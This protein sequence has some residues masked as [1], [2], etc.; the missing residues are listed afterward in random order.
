MKKHHLLIVGI[1]S[2]LG[3]N[4]CSVKDQQLDNPVS[5]H[6][7]AIPEGIKKV[8]SVAKNVDELVIPFNQYE[9]DN[10]LTVIIHPDKS[11]P[12]VHVDVTYHVGSAREELGKS[13]FAHFFEHMMF[14]GSEN[15][16][17][18]Q[19]FSLITESGGTLN[20]STNT[21]RT[22]YYETV[23][24]NQLE[25][26][27][28]LESD[29]MG[30]FLDAVTTEKFENQR[31][32]VKN[33]RGQNYD[34]RPYGLLRERVNE[35]MYPEGHPYSW[36]TIGYIEDL[37]RANLNDLKEFFLRWYGPNNA[38]LTIGGDLD[39][40]QTLAWVKQYFGGIPRGPEV[41]EPEYTKITLPED[42]YISMED[43]VS[44]PLMYMT[45]PTV[46]LNHPDEAPLD[47]L[48]SILGSG[49]TS[50]LYKNMVKNGKAVQAQAGHGCQELGCQFSL[51]GLPTPG[52]SLAELEQI[53]RAS[54]QEFEERGGAED[55]DLE[56][57]KASIVSGMVYGLESVSGK[58]SQLA[59]YQTYRNNPNGI[60]DDVARYENVTKDDVMRVYK[61]YIKNQHAVIM[62]IVP[63]GQLDG[64]IKP[65]TWQ[66]YQRNI[67][68]TSKD[69]TLAL[70]PGT[71]SFDRSVI[72][73]SGKNPSI[74]V[75]AIYRL[76]TNNGIH[77]L[78]TVNDEVPTTTLSLR[79]A[80]GQTRESIDKLGLASLTAAMMGEATL[81]SSAEELSNE[82]QKLGS[83][84]SFSSGD[85]F[86]TVNI[87]TLTKNLTETLEI[88]VE[89]LT[90]PKFAE[91]DFL[92]LQ[93]QQVEGLKNAKK[94][95]SVTAT[96]SFNKL[97]FGENNSFSYG[98][99]GLISTVEKL[100][101][102]D[103]KNFYAN[104]Y[105]PEASELIVVS[106]LDEKHIESAI[107]ILGS[108]QG[109]SSD[110][111][112]INPYPTLEAGT[113]YFID[114]P[115]AAQ[116]EIR[117]GKRA[118]KYDSTGEYYRADLMNYNLGG[119]FNSRIN[120]N[121]REDKGYTYGARSFFSGNDIR[122]YY[123]AQAGVRAD[124]TA[125]SIVQFRKEIAEFAKQGMT[126]QELQFVKSAIGQ[127]DARS[128]ETP[129][130]KLGF[131]STI[132]TYDLDTSF[133]DEQNA[134]LASITKEEL[135]ALATKH[136]KLDEMITVVVGDKEAVFEDLKPLFEN[137]VELDAHGKPL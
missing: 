15:V 31:E 45:F 33:E 98:N 90:K 40:A 91:V 68:E 3:L 81:T 27:L 21:D 126:D 71:S 16:A 29:R 7:I 46:H 87:R 80:A 14:Q 43:N 113:L 39:E 63:K 10:G 51:L 84:V 58:V 8:T 56:R 42:R 119:A 72:P 74:H 57:V 78:G 122:G 64:I 127:R 18:E 117:I 9:L 116:S 103:V 124:T 67:P 107:A 105:G 76:D 11:D 132:M 48:M 101:L 54:L 38:T 89:K 44:L 137:I 106:D 49:K 99:G 12:L 83:Q 23:P 135:N 77:V 28:W 62:S 5:S 109:N 114:K 26:M 69:S 125:D 86:T 108:W 34:N 88:A 2:I 115:G 37:N 41:L 20:G 134:I 61:K 96:D 121:L 94:N 25:R 82:L 70:R 130:Q 65:D 97:V 30:F 59:A 79:I 102:D 1:A 133:K 104:H 92:R 4:A 111:P 17:D 131:L 66:R 47:V 52:T 32:T 93:K 24:A 53:A 120:L 95:A 128:F 75:P 50:L 55:D 85:Q 100:T 118:L 6:E 112:K 136:L 60:G 35:A 110:A 19:H 13:G 36:L 123:R 129:K 22:N 73:P